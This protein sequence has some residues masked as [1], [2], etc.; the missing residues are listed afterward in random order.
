MRLLEDKVCL[1]TG[2]A[3]SIG[4]ASARLFVEAGAKVMLMDLSADALRA[5]AA[6][7]PA[8]RVACSAGDVARAEDV[9]SCIRAA[10]SRWDAI[11]VLFS[12]AGNAGVI[13]PLAAF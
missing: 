11:D 8:D 3:G 1:I 9:V 2:G 12:N 6:D 10:V 4:L 7:L 5:A 13:A